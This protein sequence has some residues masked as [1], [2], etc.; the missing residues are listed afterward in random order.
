MRIE[1]RDDDER[2]KF[3]Q[4]LDWA[5]AGLRSTCIGLHGTVHFEDAKEALGMLERLQRS[6]EK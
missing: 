4:A 3:A 5:L 1:F 2:D 6:I